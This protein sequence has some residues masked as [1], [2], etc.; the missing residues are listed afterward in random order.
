[1]HTII[2][3][4]Y[5]SPDFRWGIILNGESVKRENVK[6]KQKRRKDRKSS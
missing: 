4:T 5:V 2:H 6:G 1:M 3:N